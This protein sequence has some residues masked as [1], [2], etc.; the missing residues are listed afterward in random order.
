MRTVLLMEPSH[1]TSSAKS[2]GEV[3]TERMIRK[4]LLLVAGEPMTLPE[5]TSIQL[6]HRYDR[7]TA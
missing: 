6:K 3:P 5:F 2:C 1:I 7:Q 4:V